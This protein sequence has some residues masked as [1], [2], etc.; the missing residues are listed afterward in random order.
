VNAFPKTWRV[1]PARFFK[2]H[3]NSRIDFYIDFHIAFQYPNLDKAEKFKPKK[4]PQSRKIKL[5][6]KIFFVTWCLSG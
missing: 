6:L 5:L 2:N 3:L 4:L 1:S